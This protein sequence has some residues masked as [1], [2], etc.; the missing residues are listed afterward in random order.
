MECIE[1]KTSK[2]ITDIIGN[3]I[4]FITVLNNHYKLHSINLYITAL[5]GDSEE[6]ATT[7]LSK[8]DL[9]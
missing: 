8:E 9:L 1:M 5:S 7:V 4:K 3:L 6:E 2:K